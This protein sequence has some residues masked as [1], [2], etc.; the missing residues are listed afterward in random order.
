MKEISESLTSLEKEY[1]TKQ[2]KMVKEVVKIASTY[3][4]VF[5]SVNHWIAQIDV[6]LS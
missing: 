3:T 4:M 6:M 2:N 1:T 5:S